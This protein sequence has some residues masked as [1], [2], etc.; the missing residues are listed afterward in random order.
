MYYL[1]RGANFPIALEGALKLKEIAGIHAEGYSA[2]EM[3]HGPIGLIGPDMPVIFIATESKT[4]EKSIANIKEALAR[5]APV[6]AVV[7]E[8]SDYRELEDNPLIDLII[9]PRVLEFFSPIINVIPLQLFAY[10]MA[11][12]KGKNPDKPEGL[13]KSVTVE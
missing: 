1:G 13:A 11:L 3:K 10:H 2:S 8:G 4:F 9:V 7:S 6:I 12:I 5:H